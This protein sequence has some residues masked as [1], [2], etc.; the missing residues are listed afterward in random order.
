MSSGPLFEPGTGAA[1]SAVP[2]PT[3][4]HYFDLTGSEGTVAWVWYRV[5][6]ADWYTRTLREVAGPERN[7]DRHLGIEMALDGA[8]NSLSAAFDAGTAMLIQGA[9]SALQIDKPLP[10]FR[11]S[12]EN[13][14]TL[15]TKK[16]IGTDP[17]GTPN[18]RVWRLIIDVDNALDGERNPVPTGWLAVLRRLRNRVAHQDTLARH[19]NIGGP[20][21]VQAF[22]GQDAFDYLA[23]ACDQVSDLTEQMVSLAISLGVHELNTGWERPRWYDSK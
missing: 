12:W 3:G 11:Y 19:H 16:D 14:R 7:Y 4:P 21:S 20:S 6:A 13:A 9:E 15:L 22:G 1:P 18:D 17:D 23:H 8:L 5:W 2:W 10:V